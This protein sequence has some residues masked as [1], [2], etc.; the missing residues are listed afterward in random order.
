MPFFAGNCTYTYTASYSS[1]YYGC[2]FV[3]N[4]SISSATNDPYKCGGSTS[5][6]TTSV[7]VTLFYICGSSNSTPFRTKGIGGTATYYILHSWLTNTCNQNS[8]NGWISWGGAAIVNNATGTSL[9]MSCQYFNGTSWVGAGY[10]GG[11]YGFLCSKHQIRCG[12]S[13]L[14]DTKF[15]AVTN[16]SFWTQTCQ[17]C[18]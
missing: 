15:S 6:Y 7:P 2:G 5:C 18:Y 3:V 13:Y 1:Y 11:I 10:H 17:P 16:N 9:T 4:G 14:N 12:H 8:Y